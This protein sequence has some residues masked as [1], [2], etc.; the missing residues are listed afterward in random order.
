MTDKTNKIPDTGFGGTP[1]V[2]ENIADV[3]TDNKTPDT[4]V[5]EAP[6]VTEA[7][8]VTETPEAPEKKKKT[9][10]PKKPTPVNTKMTPDMDKE[11]EA[12]WV[13]Y[14]KEN[15]EL[16][17]RMADLEAMV[18]K[19][20]DSSRM[21]RF[22][23]LESGS[24]DPESSFKIS[25]Y[26]EN[27]QES[28][29]DSIS[30]ISKQHVICKWETL[31]NNVNLDKNGKEIIDQMALIHYYDADTGAKKSIKIETKFLAAQYGIIT[32]TNPI[33]ATSLLEPNGQKVR[34][35]KETNRE[36]QTVFYT[37]DS[38]SSHF[39]AVIPFQGVDYKIESTYLN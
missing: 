39:Y 36:D 34:Y 9:K 33:I 28:D 4:P 30:N 8:K 18:R 5:Q 3:K 15:E 21:N 35:R 10:A 19:T 16:K 2:V 37:R 38:D 22:D 13:D 25:I 14:A 29:G 12:K 31:S 27:V 17:Q 1:P 24:K 7:P 6:E 23:K 11:K 32:K 26:N 20:A